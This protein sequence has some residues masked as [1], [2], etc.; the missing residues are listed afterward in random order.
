MKAQGAPDRKAKGGDTMITC[1]RHKDCKGT[2]AT[3]TPTDE[4]IFFCIIFTSYTDPELRL[5][6]RLSRLADRIL[7]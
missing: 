3:C 4:E 6:D 7:T 1:T 2:Y 5:L